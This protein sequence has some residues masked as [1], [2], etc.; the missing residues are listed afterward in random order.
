[1]NPHQPRCVVLPVRSGSETG[2]SPAYCATGGIRA[3]VSGAFT[4]V[5][6]LVV[7]AV[8]G[9]LAAMLLPILAKAKESAINIKCKNNF[10]QIGIASSMYLQ[11]YG[12]YVHS[13]PTNEHGVFSLPPELLEPY[14]GS[15]QRVDG[16]GEV[17]THWVPF[18]EIWGCPQK[19]P[20]YYGHNGYGIGPFWRV[21]T[22]GLDGFPHNPPVAENQV[23]CP[24][25]MI[26]WYEC[27]DFD[28]GPFRLAPGT[29]LSEFRPPRTGDSRETYPH[30]RSAN[31]VFCDAHVE[32][33]RRYDFLKKSS[34]IRRRWNKDHAPHDEYWPDPLNP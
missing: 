17:R 32:S 14:L 15:R 30:G 24:S 28:L 23:E 4:L 5:E 13:R 2:R 11:D 16:N 25:D 34:L 10:R 31:A 18:P 22:L 29:R 20:F 27:I 33:L 19:R 21:P 6:L 1:M 12:Y 8:I 3:R 26:E 7:L 9:I